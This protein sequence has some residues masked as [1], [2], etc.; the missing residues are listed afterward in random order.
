VRVTAECL[1][2]IAHTAQVTTGVKWAAL[3]PGQ[4]VAAV[5]MR[6]SESPTYSAC[7]TD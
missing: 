5:M 7:S 1:I 4:Q 2:D 3:E 6:L